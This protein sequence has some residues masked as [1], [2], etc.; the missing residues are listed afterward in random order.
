[1]NNKPLKILFYNDFQDIVGGTEVYQKLMVEGLKYYGHE[2]EECFG[3][4]NTFPKSNLSFKQQMLEKAL[5]WQA[6]IAHLLKEKIQDFRPDV[7]H[8]NNNKLYTYT[9]LKSCNELG[10]PIV[11]SFHDFHFLKTG[12]TDLLSI[13]KIWKSRLRSVL[14]KYPSAFLSHTHI[15]GRALEE[16]QLKPVKVIPLFYDERIW[17]PADSKGQKDNHKILFFGRIEEQ[18]GVFDLLQAFEILKIRH[19][20]LELHYYGAGT[21]VDKLTKAIENSPHKDAI[22]YHGRVPQNQI[23]KAAHDALMLI[24]PTKNDEPFGLTGIEGQAAGL[25]TI[26]SNK[27][28]IPEWCIDGET[29]LLFEGENISDLSEKIEI[30]LNKEELREKLLQGSKAYLTKNFDRLTNIQH[31]IHFYK[32]IIADYRK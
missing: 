21:V 19:P 29:G 12:G 18:K 2:V 25:I 26:G 1:M 15:V 17:F 9:V 13:K 3:T 20:Y 22:Q 7:V 4:T 10:V 6:E 24:V 14:K 31:T 32:Q 27:G 23:N 11:S 30:V 5:F 8:I 28:G 16:K